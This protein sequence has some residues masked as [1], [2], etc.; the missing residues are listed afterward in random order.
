M[1]VL[2]I[3]VPVT[4]NIHL[5]YPFPTR[6]EFYPQILVNMYFFDIPTS[7]YSLP[8]FFSKKKNFIHF[9]LLKLVFDP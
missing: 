3:L 7:D 4:A 1:R 5:Q 6:Y 8:W 9:F 2:K